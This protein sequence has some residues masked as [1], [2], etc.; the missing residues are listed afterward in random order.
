MPNNNSYTE[1]LPIMVGEIIESIQQVLKDERRGLF[2]DLTFGGGGHTFK[3][4]E[5]FPDIQGIA[6]DQDQEAIQNGLVN[7]RDKELNEKLSLI[8]SNFNQSKN[9]LEKHE[10]FL[11]NDG[12]DFA[13]MD[14][15][16]ST[17]HFLDPKRGFS[18]RE[19]GPLDM[20]MDP[21]NNK[22]TAKEIINDYSAE[23]LEMIFKSYGEEK[24]SKRIANEIIEKRKTQEISTT[25]ELEEIIFNSYPKKMRYGKT[26]PATRVFQALRIHVNNELGVLEETIPEIFNLLKKGGR[27]MIITFHS[28]EDRIVKQIFRKYAREEK[29][30]SLITKKPLIPKDEEIISN[31]RSRSAKLRIIEKI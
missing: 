27:L 7:I 24:F 26:H 4:L 20:R 12:I 21:T 11:Q 13:L 16:V 10:K 25:K 30:G 9:F 23:E 22:L 17:H 29:T 8:C 3:V 28:L 1:H 6:F 15:G 19:D 5:S 18:F 31:P 14:I 2:V